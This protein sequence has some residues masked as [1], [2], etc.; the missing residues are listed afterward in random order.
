VNATLIQLLTRAHD[1]KLVIDG[2]VVPL[3]IGPLALSNP[4]EDLGQVQPNMF[5]LENGNWHIRFNG[6]ALTRRM[7]VGYLYIH[8]LL[9]QPNVLIPVAA[10]DI[11]KNGENVESKSAKEFAEEGYNELGLSVQSDH[12]EPVVPEAILRRLRHTLREME[13]DLACLESSGQRDHALEKR[14]EI[15]KVQKYL[16]GASFRGHTKRFCDQAERARTRVSNGIARAIAALQEEH[17]ALARHLDNAIHTG[18][19]CQYAPEV[20]VKWIL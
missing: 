1:V 13:E 3:T 9:K 20:E 14:Q 4:A 11:V 8:E 5:R 2:V 12:G 17:P 19:S 18:K 7:S 10:L 16:K 6:R 15:E